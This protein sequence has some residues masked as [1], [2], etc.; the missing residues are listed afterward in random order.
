MNAIKKR[1]IILLGGYADS[2]INFRGPLIDDLIAAGHSVIAAAPGVTD[3]HR[4]QL[5]RLGAEAYD[6]PVARTGLN[7]GNDL[8][9]MQ[10][11]RRL[12]RENQA[13]LLLTYTAKPNIWGAFAAKLERVPSCA[14]VT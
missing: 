3:S 8:Q 7:P 14:M 6:V 12:I 5:A 13:D 10:S 1:K 4:N 2:L 9:F 11:I